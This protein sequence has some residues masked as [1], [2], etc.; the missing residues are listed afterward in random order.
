MPQAKSLALNRRASYDYEFLDTFEG[1][2]E[3][4]GPEV[5][6]AKLGRIQLA[7]SFLQ[8]RRGELWLKN[9]Q[10]AKYAPAGPQ[11]HYLVD[12]D[13]KVLI[14][15]KEI[16][17]LMGKTQTDGLTLV[18]ISVYVAHG[19]VKLNFALARGKKQYEKRDKIKKRE[20]AR[21]DREQM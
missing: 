19:L 12:Q 6:S 21:E 20:A 15:R 4:T 7:G 1:G 8:V 5:K 9:A 17:R 10:I 16:N 13:R 18:P 2:L 14:H 3:L 11:P